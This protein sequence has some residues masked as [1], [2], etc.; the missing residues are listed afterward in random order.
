MLE[1]GWDVS[2]RDGGRD[3]CRG[4]GRETRVGT[5]GGMTPKRSDPSQARETW[6]SRDSPP[7]EWSREYHGGGI[8]PRRRRFPG[9]DCVGPASSRDTDW[10]R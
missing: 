4:G 2:D 9:I 7:E 3:W 8:H 1:G 10:G 6:M 5:R